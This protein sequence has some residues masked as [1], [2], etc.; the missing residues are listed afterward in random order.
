MALNFKKLIESVLIT[1][2]PAAE[3]AEAPAEAGADPKADETEKTEKDKPEIDSI[4]KPLYELFFKVNPPTG[5]ST[6]PQN[7]DQIT[8]T[9]TAFTDELTKINVT[10][11]NAYGPGSAPTVDILSKIFNI[12]IKCWSRTSASQ[13]FEYSQYL[14]YIELMA[15]TA[16]LAPNNPSSVPERFKKSLIP[17]S[18]FKAQLQKFET[19]IQNRTTANPIDF[20]IATA[21]GQYVATQIRKQLQQNYVGQITLEKFA[22]N[23]IKDALF[24]ILEARKKARLATLPT[25]SVPD[26]GKAVTDVLLHPEK[27]AGGTYAFSNKVSSDKVYTRAIHTELL[28]I[29]LACKRF[30]DYE[31]NRLFPKNEKGEFKPPGPITGDTA[32]E[33]FLNNASKEQDF[34]KFDAEDGQMVLAKD[35]GTGGYMLENIK[36]MMGNNDAAKEVYE[37]LLS[38][39]NYVREGE[40]VDWL[41]VIRGAGKIADGA[42]MGVPTVGGKR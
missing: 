12:W 40:I 39:A 33:V 24:Y 31:I 2:A 38:F 21:E 3:A 26:Q 42:S 37:L 7:P 13:F 23:S 20:P 10:Y 25:K 27:Y 16:N 15:Q 11:Q 9:P 35:V 29:G 28:N 5:T 41:A 22:G 8:F 19:A 1:E 36:A 30:F 4:A 18:V 32:Y 14:P 6:E 17:I 34:F